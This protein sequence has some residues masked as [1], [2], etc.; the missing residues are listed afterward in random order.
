MKM[1]VLLIV[2]G[3]FIISNIKAQGVP[4]SFDDCKPTEFTIESD[5]KPEWN[6][7][8]QSI[9]EYLNEQ[10]QNKKE[11]KR[12]K[13][14][15]YIGIVVFEDGSTCCQS[16]TNMTNKELDSIVFKKIINNMPNWKPGQLKGKPTI[17]L[18]NI[19]IEF[20]KGKVIKVIQ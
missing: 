17:F 1:K 7:S 2:L 8:K 5:K 15:I 4:V 6:Y 20:N 9:V 12:T 3:V 18:H 16:F 13:G 11:L 10:L 14:K 19:I